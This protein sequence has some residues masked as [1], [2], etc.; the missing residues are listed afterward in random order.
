[1]GRSIGMVS[2]KGGV[3]KTSSTL[4][5]G[6]ALADLGR[7]VLLVDANFSAPNLGVH[8]NLIDPKVTLHDILARKNNL[9]EAIQKVGNFDVLPSAIFPNIQINPLKLKEILRPI[10]KLR[11]HFN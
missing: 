6:K 1:M 2:L 5:L 10:K 7:K 4:S 3:G 9:S 11:F 8:L